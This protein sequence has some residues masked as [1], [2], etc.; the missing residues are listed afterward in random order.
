MASNDTDTLPGEAEP[1]ADLHEVLRG[2]RSGDR[3]S[4][5]RLYEI[6][7]QRVYRVIVRTVGLQ[8]APDVTQ[9]VF[10]QVFRKIDSFHGDSAFATW[11]YRVAMNEALQF[12][13]KRSRR[14]A[15]T[16]TDEPMS[17]HR[18]DQERDEAREL[19]EQALMRL[20]PQLRSIFVLREVEGLSYGEIAAAADIP[21]GTVGSRLNRARRELRQHLTDLGW[22]P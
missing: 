3:F 1:G 15:Q 22:E 12:L 6:Y 13:R 16:L 2:C 20:D 7:H 18:P 9:Q 4:Q 10:M 21:E 17:H 8:D 19:L 5:Q 11:L 14:R